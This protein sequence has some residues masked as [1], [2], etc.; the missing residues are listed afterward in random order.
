MKNAFLLYKNHAEI[1][2]KLSD[3]QAGKL[4]KAI[5]EYERTGM[6]PELEP[7]LDMAFTPI[8][9]T[10]D[11]DAEKYAQKVEKRREAG[12][13]GGKQRVANQANATFAKQT[14]ANQA[15]INNDIDNDIKDNIIINNDNERSINIS[16]LEKEKNKKEKVFISSSN[17]DLMFD[18]RI[19]EVFSLYK[20]LCPN[21][22]PL[23]FEERNLERRQEVK[24]LLVL[25]K[26]DLNYIQ[27]LFMRANEQ[28]T[29]YDNKINLKSLIKNHEAIYQGLGKK[30]SPQKETAE[31]MK[32]KFKEWEQRAKEREKVN[33]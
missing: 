3:E 33:G 23:V 30:E 14:Q 13:K 7:L 15:I 8:K 16:L 11:I 27:G 19:N 4:I 18:K 28:I 12:S 32:D 9:Q 26:N 24:N 5:F 1:F 22:C 10:I 29:F 2:E 17:P 20:R 6:T 31:S 21:L 25:C